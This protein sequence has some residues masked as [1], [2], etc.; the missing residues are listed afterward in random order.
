VSLML[1]RP[2]NLSPG[3]HRANE[4]AARCHA[5]VDASHSET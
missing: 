5:P 4:I 1:M 3:D 2:E